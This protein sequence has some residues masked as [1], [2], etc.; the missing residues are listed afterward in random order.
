VNKIHVRS[1]NFRKF[2]C[3]YVAHDKEGKWPQKS[4][5][6]T[7]TSS[8]ASQWISHILDSGWY[9]HFQNKSPCLDNIWVLNDDDVMKPLW[10]I[11]QECGRSPVWILVCLIMELEQENFRKQYEHWYGCSPVCLRIWRLKS[12]FDVKGFEQTWH[13]MR[14]GG[15]DDDIWEVVPGAIW[16]IKT[17]DF[18]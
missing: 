17:G 11:L 6:Y 18:C 10:H 4:W 3:A 8:I 7:N 2:A 9:F 12:D 5:T 1:E 13:F 16:K 15:I 14:P